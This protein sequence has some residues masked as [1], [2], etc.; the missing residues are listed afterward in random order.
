MKL[1]PMLFAG[2]LVLNGVLVVFAWR[3]SGPSG[4][5]PNGTPAGAIAGVHRQ[6]DTSRFTNASA[7]GITWDDLR[8]D[9]LA[10]LVGR[11]RAAGF[12]PLVVQAV[13]IHLLGE[14]YA[15]SERAIYY[16]NGDVPYWRE[17]PDEF[18]E[19]MNA[20]GRL[21]HERNALLKKLL[22]PDAYFDE[23]MRGFQRRRYGDLPP[24]KLSRLEQIVADYEELNEQVRPAGRPGAPEERDK[25]LA[26]TREMRFDLEKLLTPSE[27]DQYDLR[28]S[29]TAF[30]LRET[31]RS[32]NA[33]EAEYR[34][35]FPLFR[36]ID[37][38]FPILYASGGPEDS[39]GRE[40]AMQALLPAIASVLGPE[41]Y[42]DYQQATAQEY[43]QLNRLMAR[44]DLPLSTARAVTNVQREIE[45]RA[46]EVRSDPRLDAAARE[47]ELNALAQSAE[48]KITASLGIRGLEAY[49]QYGGGWL[50][51][52][53]IRPQSLQP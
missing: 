46:R 32:F 18:H 44:L 38:E 22:G 40:Q 35:L 42:A 9:D 33:T 30:R 34:A 6:E 21:I 14:R 51:T 50:T 2:S 26:L 31:L 13:V 4:V 25:L 20:V 37:E 16:P 29:P 45:Q 5:L 1:L 7:V 12:S 49:K 43:Q 53:T 17:P 23:L 11:L 24:A 41:R 3:T 47:S 27:L 10:T 39:V 19:Q 15:A 48:A 8:S 36:R 28:S 52:L